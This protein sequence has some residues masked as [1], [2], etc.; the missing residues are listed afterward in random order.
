MTE[1]CDTNVLFHAFD[2]GSPLHSK[3]RSYLESKA[4]SSDF[5]L[6]ELV[7]C[8]LYGLLRRGEVWSN[9]MTAQ[10]ASRTIQ[11]LRSNE[12]WHIIDYPGGLMSEVWRRASQPQFPRSGVFDARLALTLRHHGVSHFATRNVKH[13]QGYGFDEV[14]D[15]TV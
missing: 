14:F 9:P 6:C 11:V 13:F 3:A 7:L 8:E 4:A 1:S 10:E 2:A 5:V 12:A 15:P